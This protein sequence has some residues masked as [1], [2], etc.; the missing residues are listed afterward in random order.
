MSDV[1]VVVLDLDGGDRLVQCLSALTLQTDPPSGI[2]V[3]DNGSRTPVT[4]RLPAELAS[5]VRVL[6][7]CRNTGFTGG[8]NLAMAEVSAPFV[9]WVN[10][11]A[12]VDASWIATLRA[13]FQHQPR[14][15]AVQSVV[16]REDGLV[17]GAG[18]AVSDGRF[19]QVAHGERFDGER[20]LPRAW[21]V[22][23]TAAIYRVQALREVALD[24]KVLHPAF[25]AWYEDVELCARLRKAGWGLEVIPAALAVHGGS[26]S[27]PRIGGRA[28]T[29]RVRNRYF[30]RRLHPGVGSF[31]ALLVEDLKRV[32]RLSFGGRVFAVARTKLAVLEGLFGSLRRG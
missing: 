23:A 22:S 32:L 18:I 17:D 15:A 20:A 2:I 12:E 27:A 25:F 21:G 29:L 5:R 19:T 10:N 14:L 6:R 13:H 26:V 28:L 16:M 1:Q 3:V 31:P 24:G 4:E 30:V 11:D 8:I 9:A 7:L